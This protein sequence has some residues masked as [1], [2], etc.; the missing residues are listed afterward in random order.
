MTNRSRFKI[1][2]IVMGLTI[3]AIAYLISF[4]YYNALEISQRNVLER[5]RA[6]TTTA[7]LQIDGSAHQ[8]V[9]QH[10]TNEKDTIEN[11]Y[12]YQLLKEQ[13]I[14]IHR[15]S[16]LDA[17]LYTIFYDST[18]KQLEYGIT[19][20]SVNFFRQRMVHY[21]E[22]LLGKFEVGGV[23]HSY[24]TENGE[25]LSAF[26]PIKNT[27]GETVGLLVADQSCSVFTSEAHRELTRQSIIAVTTVLPL[28]LLLFFYTRRFLREQKEYERS[29]QKQQTAIVNQ[30]R[31]IKQQNNKLLK[32]NKEI[33]SINETLDKLVK[34]RTQSLLK[35]TEE[36]QTYLYRSSH[37]M[38]GPVS[39]ILGLVRLMAM[40]SKVEPYARMIQDSAVLLSARIQSL[41]DVYEIGTR[42]VNLNEWSLCELLEDVR[43]ELHA[44]GLN[45][46][47][48][49][50]ETE[51]C[52]PLKLDKDLAKMLL[53]ETVLNSV[54]HNRLE[55]NPTHVWVKTHNN[56]GMLN[57]EVVDN[58]IGMDKN[59]LN[60]AFQMFFRGHEKSQGIG[61]GLFKVKLIVEKLKGKLELISNPD[62][63]ASVRISLPYS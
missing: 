31:I 18:S 32:K 62:G 60:H 27:K 59:T 16:E 36:L 10:W 6:I 34:E 25:V 48:L 11:F 20:S 53:K 17:P 21:P 8:Q 1:L 26:A 19:S 49:C 43:F 37:D 23:L 50:Q 38:R 41:S 3:L 46:Y 9:V 42:K 5:L 24:P 13:L 22:V 40:E 56:S 52:E 14:R 44:K 57:I 55:N 39:S 45:N 12:P 61:L 58:G 4:N 15:V 35:T 51:S 30:S 7:S 2:W 54:Y 29:L 63:G 33:A 47:L 28:V